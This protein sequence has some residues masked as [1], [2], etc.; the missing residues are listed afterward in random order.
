MSITTAGSTDSHFTAATIARWRLALWAVAAVLLAAPWVAMRF[1]D[2]VRWDA[3][4]FLVFGGMLGIAG[5]AVEMVVRLSRRRAVV[6]GAVAL[7]GAAFL[8]VWVELA[9]G[10]GS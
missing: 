10:V 3:L 6:L 9:V 5:G 7:V 2:E 1:T 8:L 4:D